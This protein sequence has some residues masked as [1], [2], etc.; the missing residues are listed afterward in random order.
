MCAGWFDKVRFTKMSPGGD[1][2]VVYDRRGRARDTP[3]DTFVRR[4]QLLDR[5][6]AGL[7]MSCKSADMPVIHHQG[8]F[9]YAHK[10][11]HGLGTVPT[12]GK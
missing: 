11:Q 5:T 3:I 2:P 9:E 4:W 1:I 7:M 6:C 10:W 12:I 8:E